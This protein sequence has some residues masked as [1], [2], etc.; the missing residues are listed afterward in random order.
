MLS[1]QF[2]LGAEPLY[3]GFFSNT[4][5]QGYDPVAYF[6]DG[7]PVK[8]RKDLTTDYQGV[9]IRFASEAHRAQF[10]ESPDAYLPQYGGY[11]AWAVAQNKTAKGDARYW[12]IVDDKL[13]LNYDKKVQSTWEGDIPGFI[14]KADGNWP[15]VLN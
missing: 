12:K 5:I 9:E 3:T 7:K 1:P 11:C 8:G 14:E 13:Y 15:T 4:F 10:L 2:A 6:T